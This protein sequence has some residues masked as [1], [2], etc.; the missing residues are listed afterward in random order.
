M[1]VVCLPSQ[2]EYRSSIFLKTVTCGDSNGLLCCM[3]YH[4]RRR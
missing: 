1:V 4:G 3:E 2:L